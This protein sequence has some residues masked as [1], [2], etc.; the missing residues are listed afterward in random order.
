MSSY[1]FANRSFLIFA[2]GLL[3]LAAVPV[4]AAGPIELVEIGRYAGS[5]AEIAAYDPTTRLMYVTG[6]DTVQVVDLT[7]PANPAFAYHIPLVATSVAAKNGIVAIAAKSAKNPYRGQ[8]YVIDANHPNAP[9]VAYSGTWADMVTFSPDGSKIITANE[10]EP[11]DGFDPEGSVGIIDV[12]G[13]VAGA[14]R[15]AVTVS[16][17]A[18]NPVREQLL[19]QGVRIFPNAQS[20]AQDL[21]PEYVAI[22]PD[23]ATA[24]VTLQE[25]N[26]L[27]VV[28]VATATATAI[29]PLGLKD[30][31]APGNGLDPSDR[32][33]GINIANWPVMGMYMPDAITSF[34][35]GGMTYL[36][37]ANE[38]DSRDEE[39]RVRN[40]SLDPVAFPDAGA[41]RDNANLGR[42]NVSAINGDADGDGDYDALYA[43]GARSFSIWDMSGR[44]V[45]D[46]GDQI[47]Q[48]TAASTPALF[49]TDGGDPTLFDTRSDNK[50]PEPEALTTGVVDGA[51]YLFVG[52]ERAGG[53]V[54]VYD[55]TDP[56]SPVFV[57][58]VRSD[59]DV[60]PEGLTFISALDSPTGAPLLLV[61]NE[62][63]N[64]VAIYEIRPGV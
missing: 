46:S 33:G 7:D 36:A 4:A 3:L 12:S 50:G 48:L 6:N 28:D 47:E 51:P 2:L 32:D 49:N 24:Y 52:L 29:L 35:A 44:L 58:Y 38:G 13:G 62:V 63:S 42:L 22:S 20:V 64:T 45:F 37:T 30:H 56:A 41:L 53:G 43:Y 26:S 10:G 55:V 9:K 14:K 54:L 19:A 18:F 27:A 59:T 61:A 25:N 1:K 31:N 60:A 11:G 40:L 23:G 57:Q 34:S 15:T 16:F 21:E 17:T 5:G 39:V 8:V